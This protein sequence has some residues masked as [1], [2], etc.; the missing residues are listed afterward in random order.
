MVKMHG[1]KTLANGATGAFVLQ[2]NG[3]Y[4]WRI[5]K[6]PPKKGGG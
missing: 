4:A 5:I 2:D 3:K 1:K 6:G